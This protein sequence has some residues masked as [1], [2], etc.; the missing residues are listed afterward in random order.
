MD[1][2][3]KSG[4][5]RRWAER[6]EL[7]VAIVLRREGN[8]FQ[9]GRLTSLGLDAARGE[10]NLPLSIGEHCTVHLRLATTRP[11]VS[12]PAIVRV[13]EGRHFVAQ[14]VCP[15]AQS[16]HLLVEWFRA[17]R[18]QRRMDLRRHEKLIAR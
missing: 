17:K 14:L 13:A 4:W 11:V 3:G 12:L 8:D 9:P 15:D 7:D 16:M 18:L 1:S 2:T 5:R 10:C 6:Y